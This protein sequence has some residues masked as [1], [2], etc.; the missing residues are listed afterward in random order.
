MVFKSAAGSS[1]QRNGSKEAGGVQS[2]GRAASRLLLS[3]CD[4]DAVAAKISEAFNVSLY[5]GVAGEG[6][7]GSIN[8]A[9]GTRD[10]LAGGTASPSDMI[11]G[12]SITKAMTATLALQM[13]EQGSKASWIWTLLPCITLIRGRCRMCASC[14]PGCGLT[15]RGSRILPCGSS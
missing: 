6:I 2:L 7:N 13:V 12:G 15:S 11:P 9:A 3:P 14:F 4:L 1:Q 10:R 5:I 8:A